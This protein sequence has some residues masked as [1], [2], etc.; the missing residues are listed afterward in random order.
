MPKKDPGALNATL[1]FN[2]SNISGRPLLSHPSCYIHYLSSRRFSHDQ[3]KD[4]AAEL[5]IHPQCK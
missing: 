2:V 5:L 1:L 3:K 4:C